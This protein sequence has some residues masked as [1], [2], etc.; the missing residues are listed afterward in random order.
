[1]TSPTVEDDRRRLADYLA[2]HGPTPEHSLR[3]ALRWTPARFL[4]AVSEPACGWFA[5][6]AGGWCLTDNGG[7]DGPAIGFG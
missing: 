4:A 6:A 3:E 1:M 5:L 2:D 7:R